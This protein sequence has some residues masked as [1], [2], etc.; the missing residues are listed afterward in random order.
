MT[1]AE[2]IVDFLAECY[3][4]QWDID[5]DDISEILAGNF[6]YVRKQNQ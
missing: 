5:H 1:T 4:N 6:D 3:R 2:Q